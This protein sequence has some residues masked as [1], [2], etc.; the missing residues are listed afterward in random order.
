MHVH[1]IFLKMLVSDD[2]EEL[3]KATLGTCS[4]FIKNVE[5]L[6]GTSFIPQDQK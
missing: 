3:K 6:A 2:I 4:A 5:M 1:A